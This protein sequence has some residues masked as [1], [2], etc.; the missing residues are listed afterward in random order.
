MLQVVDEQ[1]GNPLAEIKESIGAEQYTLL[2]SAVAEVALEIKS[3]HVAMDGTATFSNKS[4]EEIAQSVL[5]HF[6]A[7]AVE[8]M[9]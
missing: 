6:E 2:V 4:N 7:A 3:F 9:Q 8:R 1:G 5:I